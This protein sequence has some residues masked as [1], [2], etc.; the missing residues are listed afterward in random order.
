MPSKS[1]LAIRWPVWKPRGWGRP[2]K[3]TALPGPW[4]GFD[5]E[6]DAKRGDFV[7]AWA[8]G[9][10]VVECG[11]DFSKYEPGTYWIWNLPYDIEGLLRDLGASGVEEAW[12]A[13]QDGAEFEI[14]GE[15]AK[16]YHGKRFDF[17]RGKERISFIEASSFFGRVPLSEIG[18]KEKDVKA[19]EMSKSRF[20]VDQEYRRKVNLYC[21]QDAR[22]VYNAI[23]DLRMGVRTL[24]VELGATPGATARRFMNRVGQFPEILWRTHK[25]FLRSYCG[26]RFEITK[27]GFIPNV[28]QYDL[29]SAY[30][31]ALAQCP[32]LT[33][34]ATAK[35]TRRFSE[36]ALYGSYLV[37]FEYDNYLGVAPRWRDNVRV[38]SAAQEETWLTRPEVDWLLRQGAKVNVIRG[39]EVFDPNATALWREIITELFAM[40]VSGKGKPEGMG[41]KII[42]NSQ[43]GILI[44]L[45]RASGAWVPIGTAMNPIDFAGRLELEEPPKE[46]E[47]GNRFAPLY[48]GNLT[49]LTRVRLL[50][51]AL[52]VGEEAYIGG[53]TDSALTTRKFPDWMINTDLGGWKLEKF[54]E[55]AQVC[56]TGMYA[57]GEVVKVRGITRKGTPD[58][59]WQATHTRN[60]RVGMKSANH[61]GDVS[62]IKPKVVANNFMVEKKRKWLVDLAEVTI[63]RREFVDSRALTYLPKASYPDEMVGVLEV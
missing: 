3:N 46:F 51:A 48:A 37:D 19:S 56:K 32:W 26:G 21:Q 47:G 17:G 22:I 11:W 60:S 10:K 39:V 31:W 40:K 50:D 15:P 7:C 29:V 5:T 45:I 55:M 18:A 2:G 30:P 42:L 38:Y 25:A 54:A 63:R 6:R 14:L 4:F 16:Y 41:A 13:R 36:K 1:E 28:Y 8:V 53:H 52:E 24:G 62:L 43:Y 35:A 61:W 34:T 58:L 59:L 49:A 12:A 44:Q 9:E 20:E 33:Q 27:R 57:M 23:Q